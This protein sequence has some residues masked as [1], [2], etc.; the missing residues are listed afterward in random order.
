[1]KTSIVLLLKKL[2]LAKSFITPSHFLSIPISKFLLCGFKIRS[3]K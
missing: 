1:L 3:K 2:P